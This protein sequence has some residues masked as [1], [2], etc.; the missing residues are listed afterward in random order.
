MS[1]GATC[2]VPWAREG[3]GAAHRCWRCGS[4]TPRAPRELQDAAVACTAAARRRADG[5]EST[6]SSASIASIDRCTP[7]KMWIVTFGSRCARNSRS[8]RAG[9]RAVGIGSSRWVQGRDRGLW[10][11]VEVFP[12]MHTCGPN[13]AVRAMRDRASTATLGAGDNRRFRG[14]SLLPRRS[15]RLSG[16]PQKTTA[17]RQMA[18]AATAEHR[19][20]EGTRGS[21]PSSCSSESEATSHA[22]APGGGVGRQPARL[23]AGPFL[24]L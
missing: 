13:G 9:V 23:K 5:P 24:S 15:P 19:P 12:W 16:A 6:E 17:R 8:L 1:S 21:R 4:R 10:R 7:V 11:G 2:G 22:I 20:S 18:A 3:F 14:G